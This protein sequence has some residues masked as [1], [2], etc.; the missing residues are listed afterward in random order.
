MI[1]YI[2]LVTPVCSF[3]KGSVVP[4]DAAVPMVVVSCVRGMASHAS[5]STA[6]GNMCEA[7]I[8]GRCIW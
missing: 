7:T 4:D 8:S 5:T 2:D 1:D 6:G 3:G